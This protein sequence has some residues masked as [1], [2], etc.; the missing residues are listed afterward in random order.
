LGIPVFPL[1]W[2]DP[3]SG[4]RSEGFRERGFFAEAF[5]NILAFLGWNPGTEQEVFTM[6]ELIKTFSVERI[7]KAGARF[8]ME[9]AKWYNQQFLVQTPDKKVAEKL[10]PYLQEY[11]VQVP[12]EYLT[13]VCRLMK[14]R[15]YFIP[16]IYKE[17]SYFFGPVKDYE[18]KV[19][20][21]KWGDE[22]KPFFATLKSKLESL[23]EFDT[24]TVESTVKGLMNEAG[25]KFGQVLP[26][27]RVMLCGT[28]QGPPIFEVAGL[29]GQKT[30][31]NRMQQFMEKF[32]LN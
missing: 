14:E 17:G 31:V 21:K 15:A 7:G 6:D 30:V 22:V 4:E 5:I 25:L 10:K 9:K 1:N 20:R 8:D 26:V 29:L 19:V 13:E 12:D 3:T 28:V 11:N 2:E 32:D 27:F 16:D 23:D 18:E 24:E